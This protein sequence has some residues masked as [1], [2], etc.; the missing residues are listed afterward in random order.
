[1]TGN[2]RL[3]PRVKTENVDRF[4]KK[5]ATLIADIISFTPGAIGVLL[6]IGG[7][8]YIQKNKG[9]IGGLAII[10]CGLA[11]MQVAKKTWNY[12]YGGTKNDR[13]K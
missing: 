4:I 5:N 3:R 12:F 8:N 13:N 11:L 1:M 10:A 6:Y 9:M 7:A 2:I